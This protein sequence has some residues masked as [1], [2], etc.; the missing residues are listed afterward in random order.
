MAATRLSIGGENDSPARELGRFTRDVASNSVTNM[1]VEV[2]WR[3]DRYLRGGDH[4]P[5]LDE[6]YPAARFTEQRENFDHQHQNVRIENGIQIGDLTEFVDFFYTQ[7][8]G[9]VTGAAIWSLANGPAPPSDVKLNTTVLSNESQLFWTQGKG[10]V[11]AEIVWRSTDV[12]FWTHV[13]EV[14]DVSTATLDLSK[15]NVAFGVRSVGANGFRSPAVFPFP[16]E[17]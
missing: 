9:K 12:P 13:V 16:F 6:G 14:G 5:F 2:I 4:E 8:V 10:A 1:S 17:A 15:D 7:R 11:A 3:A